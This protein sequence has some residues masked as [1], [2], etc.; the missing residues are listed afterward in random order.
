MYERRVKLVVG[1]KPQLSGFELTEEATAAGAAR[2]DITDTRD[3]ACH[4]FSP[5]QGQ[6][7]KKEVGKRD[8]RGMRGHHQVLGLLVASA[9]DVSLDKAS[10]RADPS[11]VRALGEMSP[12]KPQKAPW[13]GNEPGDMSETGLGGSKTEISQSYHACVLGRAK[14]YPLPAERSRR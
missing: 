5:G 10:R 2:E 8:P 4:V 13:P 6:V 9:P 11:L 14:V 1:S 7:K 12:G 3:R